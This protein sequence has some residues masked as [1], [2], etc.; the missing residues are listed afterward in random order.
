MGVPLAFPADGV[1]TVTCSGLEGLTGLQYLLEKSC[2]TWILMS[3]LE[4]LKKRA[5][6][7][8]VIS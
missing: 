6:V 7:K 3:M 5:V 8:K 1:E 4:L 2:Q